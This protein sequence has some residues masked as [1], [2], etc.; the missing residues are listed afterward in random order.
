MNLDQIAPII[1]ALAKLLW[2]VFAFYALRLLHPAI[3]GAIGRLNNLEA[4]GVKLALSGGSAMDAA[5]ALADRHPDW[6]VEIP[7][8]DRKAALDRANANRRSFE[9]AEILWVDDCPSNN[10]NEARMLRSFGAMVTFAATTEEALEALATG[11]A[12]SHPFDLILSDVARQFPT[13]NEAAGLEMLPRLRA[14]GHR[15]NVIFYV[16]RLQEGAGTPSGAFALTNRPD[17]LLNYVTDSL[18]RRRA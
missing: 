3:A 9:G 4:F 7:A 12:Q 6:K 18:S 17:Q 5:I 2:V 15:Q 1:G 8:A 10:R 11:Q 14:A 16:G 13:P